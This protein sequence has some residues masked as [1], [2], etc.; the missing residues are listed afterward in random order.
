M[1]A[2]SP[3]IPLVSL[4]V[5]FALL[6]AG[7][8]SV[9]TASGEAVHR[10]QDL[11][12]NGVGNG[13]ALAIKEALL[14]SAFGSE[15]LGA[16]VTQNPTCA[17]IGAKWNATAKDIF[18]RI[19]SNVVVQLEMDIAAV[20]THVSPPLPPSLAEV[21]MGRD[22]L[23]TESDR[24]G[25][26]ERLLDKSLAIMG[27]YKCA[28]GFDCMFTVTPL[29]L[30]APSEDYDWGCGLQPYNCSG[31]CW[32]PVNKTKFWGQVSTMLNM[33][34][35]LAGDDFRLRSLERD[36]YRYRLWQSNTAP[37]NPYFQLAAS[38]P[39][40]VKPMVR[41]ISAY[42]LLWY[43]ELEPVD[44]WVPA[45]RGP[46][47][48]AVV[49]GSV[50][51]SLLV[52]WLL[53]SKEQ[54]NRLLKAMLPGKVIKQLQDG[55]S[56]VAQEYPAVTV[57]FSDIVGYTTVAS[58]LSAWQV[59]TLLNELFGMFDELTQRNGVYK[60]ETIGDAILCV[61]G[62]PV[63]DD[64]VRNAVR[65]A[66]MALDMVAAVERFKPSLEGVRVQ[67]R[68][69]L[70]SGPV[71]AGVVGKKMP[72]F[73][74]FGDT[75][76]TASRMESTS[77]SM[78]VQVSD[79]T[80]ALLRASG[81]PFVLEPRGAINIKGKGAMETFWLTSGP[82]H[83]DPLVAQAA[84]R[85]GL[86]HRLSNFGAADPVRSS[87]SNHQSQSKCRDS[88]GADAG[89]GAGAGTGAG[90]L[91]SHTSPN[92]R[93]HSYNPDRSTQGKSAN[94]TLERLITVLRLG[95]T[96]TGL[97]GTSSRCGDLAVERAPSGSGTSGRLGQLAL[98]LGPT[99]P[100]VAAAT[101]AVAAE[102]DVES[103]GGEVASTGVGAT[104]TTMLAP[105]VNTSAAGGGGPGASSRVSFGPL[106]S[107]P[108]GNNSRLTPPSQSQSTSAH[109]GAAPAPVTAQE[110]GG[111]GG[112]ARAASSDHWAPPSAAAD[113]AAGPAPLPVSGAAQIGGRGVGGAT[114]SLSTGG[115]SAAASA[116]RLLAEV[117]VVAEPPD[118][119][120]PRR[121]P[122]PAAGPSVARAGVT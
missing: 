103:L 13:A 30:P 1:L 27:P 82:A 107:S 8:A 23:K 33:D 14:V 60:V 16:F 7:L 86:L 50:A 85:G 40:P 72:R 17:E 77:T 35:L 15:L 113:A 102:K 109:F 19:N 32:D 111:L 110:A 39:P 98:S 79:V 80:A 104:A 91:D 87:L 11:A 41:S 70:H 5:F 106:T 43:L 36:G 81:E 57:L 47:I 108:L 18:K 34:P 56:T 92:E 71:V 58:Q 21:L 101:M 96:E 29:F 74:L 78:R 25:V 59:V 97:S 118:V 121:A 28:E 63:P 90:G 44:G 122:G 62:C 2:A 45:W 22:L 68:V 42:N 112:G 51:V 119:A 88:G 67:I 54:H 38:E 95:R 120:A 20:I 10:A 3:S 66:N 61:A 83:P 73:C 26:I 46:C 93:P 53:V 89:A 31:L 116:R 105:G 6:A 48:A 84:P 9:L 37:S 100:A 114:A 99:P 117:V 75:V 94:R 69:G 65:A 12:Y 52:L 115:A 4:L 64:A 24:P 76:N 49:V 55:E